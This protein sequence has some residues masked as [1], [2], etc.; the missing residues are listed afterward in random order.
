M[1]IYGRGLVLSRHA[2]KGKKAGSN[3]RRE[4]SAYS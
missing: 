1:H 2:Q 4:K 3:E